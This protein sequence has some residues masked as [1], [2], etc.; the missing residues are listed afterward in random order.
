MATRA[1]V[2]SVRL[3]PCSLKYSSEVASAGSG[4]SAFL[5]YSARW[6]TQPLH[7]GD[8]IFGLSPETNDLALNAVRGVHAKHFG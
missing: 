4:S 6:R 3:Y 5:E 7:I 2:G 1:N 8:K